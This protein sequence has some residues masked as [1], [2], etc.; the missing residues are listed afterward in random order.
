MAPDAKTFAALQTY[1][2]TTPIE[3]NSDYIP[4]DDE[5]ELART[6]VSSGQPIEILTDEEVKEYSMH[7]FG[8]GFD[9]NDFTIPR[10]NRT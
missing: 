10:I 1:S 3:N 6:K 9:S 2:V 8:V 4:R 7:D 5:S